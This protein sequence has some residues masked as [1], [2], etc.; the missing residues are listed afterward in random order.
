MKY[1]LIVVVM[2]FGSCSKKQCCELTANKNA[3]IR[4]TGDVAVDG[5]DWCIIVDGA[6]YH[7][8]RV[9]DTVFM[10]DSLEVKV[11]YELTSQKFSCGFGGGMP[12]INV[13]DIK[14]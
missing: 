5:C 9:L 1:L 14:K 2:M 12:V 11:T 13:V 8:E 10:H 6:S 3:I 4:W 7:P